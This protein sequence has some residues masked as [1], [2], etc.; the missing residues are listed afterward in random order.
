M[1]LLPSIFSIVSHISYPCPCTH[2]KGVPCSWCSWCAEF[3]LA[4]L[5]QQQT[6][7]S[8][9]SILS[10]NWICWDPILSTPQTAMWQG[11]CNQCNGE[12]GYVWH[13]TLLRPWIIVPI[14]DSAF[15]MTSMHIGSCLT[16][17]H[18]LPS[19]LTCPI[20]AFFLSLV[21][22]KYNS[23]SV[24]HRPGFFWLYPN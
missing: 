24:N 5:S 11:S 18:S 13:S 16:R 22:I 7:L 1:I 12:C 4:L 19:S 6:K 10:G 8:L 9:L 15:I 2:R 14:M 17:H 21:L 3:L 20:S 23:K